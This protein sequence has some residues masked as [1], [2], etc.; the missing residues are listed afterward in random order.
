MLYEIYPSRSSYGFIIISRYCFIVGKP[1]ADGT[2]K[3]D[4]KSRTNVH[5]R[6]IW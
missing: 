5:V 3:L 1:V 4:I 2:P 6:L